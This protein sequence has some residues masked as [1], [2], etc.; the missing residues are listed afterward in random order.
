MK[1]KNLKDTKNEGEKFYVPCRNII[2]LVYA[3]ALAESLQ[4]KTINSQT[5]IETLTG[6]E[7]MMNKYVNLAQEAK[8]EILIISIGEPVPDEV[9]LVNRDVLEKCLLTSLKQNGQKCLI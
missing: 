8:K 4:I 2:F 1:R 7:K 3:L 5:K 9:K 6:W